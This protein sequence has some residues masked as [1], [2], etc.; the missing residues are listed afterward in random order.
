MSPNN[1]EKVSGL[2]LVESSKDH[3]EETIVD[4]IK[5]P[6]IETTRRVKV[7]LYARTSTGDDRQVLDNQLL[8][9]RE[10]ADKQGWDIHHEY[11]DKCSGGTS[12]R[13]GLRELMKDS[14]ARRFNKVLVVKIDRFGR[15]ATDL[16]NLIKELED[17]NITFIAI[18]QGIDTSTSMGRLFRTFLAGIAEFE[19]D[20]IRERVLAGLHRARQEGKKIGRPSKVDHNQIIELRK[21]NKSL[22]EIAMALGC[23][24]SNVSK[25]LKKHP[26]VMPSMPVHA[27][28]IEKNTD[29]NMKKDMISQ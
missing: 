6:I 12:D 10:Y 21:Q 4:T 16:L 7:A 23:T 18:D 27:T 11:T 8:P 22:S 5:E 9:M 1:N 29:M 20:L 19:R 28:A 3:L 2:S 24:P 15:S 17:L 14:R 25:V 13:P 26:S